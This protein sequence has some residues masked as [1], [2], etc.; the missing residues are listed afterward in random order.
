M[1]SERDADMQL[2]GFSVLWALAVLF[3]QGA[4]RAASHDPAQALVALAALV[5]L[6]RPGAT[7]ALV[8]MAG[9][10]LV[11]LFVEAPWF[12][13]HWLLHGFVNT[14]LLV[15]WLMAASRVQ[16]ASPSRAEVV[17]TF[18]PVARWILLIVYFYGTFHKINTDFLDPATSCGASVYLRLQAAW[19]PFLPNAHWAV[20]ATTWGTLVLEGSF[21]VLLLVPRL[22]WL[23]LGL[24]L[25]FHTA[26]GLDLEVPYYDFSVVLYALF[27]LWL[28]EDFAS[29]VADRLR[30]AGGWRAAV[31][32]GTLHAGVRTVVAVAF[33]GVFV[34]EAVLGVSVA[35]TLAVV[36]R[37][38]FIAYAAILA[39]LGV[40][41]AQAGADIP[42]QPNPDILRLRPAAL[43]ILPL[44]YLFN[45]MSPYLG[46]K[47]ET[48]LAMYSNLRTEGGHLNHL[49]VPARLD[50]F[51]WQDDLVRVVAS[52]DPHLQRIAQPNLRM[53]W[54]EFRDY[55]SGRPQA[56]V[57]YERGGQTVTV[58]RAGDVPDF[59]DRTNVLLRKLVRFRTVDVSEPSR[60]TH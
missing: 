24:A 27:F 47:T 16:Q 29:T 53:T 15:A 50:P 48:S 4:H 28:P 55:L 46:L 38:M 49:L 43:A 10:Q 23:V 26:L 13:N 41:A 59:R 6:V 40:V 3:H 31:A 11:A 39:L 33:L 45:G 8:A 52:S 2:T 12:S 19:A 22:R 17:R 58:A 35:P 32:S 57:T 5:L 1:A 56:S 51:G 30:A 14:G 34:D 18:A 44:L 9:A 25:V 20:A 37:W 36:V 21:V 42:P 54:Y 60:C 7:L